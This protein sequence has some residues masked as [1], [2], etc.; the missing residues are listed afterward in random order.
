MLDEY[1]SKITGVSIAGG[2]GKRL[3]PFTESKPKALLPVGIEKKPMLEFTIKPWV[4][5]GIKDY[6]F[7]TGYKSETIKQHFSDG[8]KFG[9]NIKYS[10][11]EEKLETGGAIKNA[12]TNQKLKKN[13]PI[14]VFYCDDFI[15]IPSKDLIKKHLIGTKEHG[16]KATMVATDSFRS[17]YGILDVEDIEQNLKKVTKFEEKPLIERHANVGIYVLE[18]EILE[19]IDEH[20]PPFKFEKVIIPKLVERELLMVYTI[21]WKNWLPVNTDKDYEKM[22]KTNMTEFY[23]NIS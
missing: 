15:K 23:S 18:P 11:E 9:I 4:N 8:T 20:Q 19:I 16:F 17:N 21:P 14:V 5:L 7:C 10:K 2:E 6:V 22:L 3:R 13:N 1:I 12:I